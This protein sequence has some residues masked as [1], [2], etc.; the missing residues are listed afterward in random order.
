MKKR[1][2]TAIA[3]VFAISVLAGTEEK[4]YAVRT[5]RPQRRTIA[6]SL[7][8][9]GSVSSPAEVLLCPKVSGRIAS[10]LLADGRLSEEGVYASKGDLLARIDDRE[11][12]IAR[13][14]AKAAVAVAR[15]LA[16]DAQREFERIERLR[17]GNVASEHDFDAARFARDRTSAALAQAEA[18]L[19]AAELNL[20][21]TSLLA[22]FDGVITAKSLHTGAMASPSSEI[23]RFA[24]VN[25]LRILFDLP[26]TAIPLV[27]P[28]K[29]KVRVFVDAYP[30]EPVELTVAD[31]FPSADASTR[32]VS[33][34]VVLPNPTRRYMPGMFARGEF[35]LDERVDV[36]TIPYSAL[37]RI[38]D[39]YCVYRVVEGRA[40]ITNVTIGFRHDDLIE[41]TKGLNDGDEIVVD[42]LH[43][44]SDGVSVNVAGDR[45]QF[46][47]AL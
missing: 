1:Y 26:T 44:L 2:F 38:K 15:A 25:P 11:Y 12:S 34:K 13:D 20:E 6:Q 42:G 43:R 23:F 30:E 4:S 19:A 9:T 28:G 35:A 40:V 36:L 7:V 39:K 16:D 14:S 45:P 21:E 3:A 33:V 29:T 5:T 37:L 17:K 18:E 27:K 41:I 8:K 32:T 10:T 47:T 24:S 22:P 46:E 31:L